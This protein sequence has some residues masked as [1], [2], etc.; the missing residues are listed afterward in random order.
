MGAAGA[1]PERTGG[2]SGTAGD[3]RVTERVVMPG[4][5]VPVVA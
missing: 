4:L 3:G 1:L 5:V 2:T